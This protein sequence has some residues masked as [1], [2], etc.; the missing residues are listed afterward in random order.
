M[1]NNSRNNSKKDLRLKFERCFIMLCDDL[2]EKECLKRHLFG[3]KADKFKDI[4]EIEP[5]D[6]GFLFNFDKDQLLGIFQASSKAQF[7]IKPAAW[8]GRF[9]AQVSVELIGG[10]QRLK[11]A[12]YVLQKAG[13]GMRQLK[14]G[15]P[16]PQFPVHGQDVGEKI[17]ANF[18]EPIK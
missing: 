5:G 10:L 16:A 2:T 15:V 9:A 7:N 17:L 12:T 3:D 11:D 6:V 4:D 13:V 18:G 1:G 14:S 8:D